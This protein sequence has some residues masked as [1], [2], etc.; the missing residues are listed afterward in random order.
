L[1]SDC[2]LCLTEKDN[3]DRH[4]IAHKGQAKVSGCYDE[5]TTTWSSGVKSWLKESL[6]VSQQEGI[7]RM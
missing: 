4:D 1:L 5:D 2:G 6:K 3:S 7:R